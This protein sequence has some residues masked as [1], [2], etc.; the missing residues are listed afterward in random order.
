MKHIGINEE[1]V[2]TEVL[3]TFLAVTFFYS[4]DNGFA[5]I[6]DL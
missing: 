5:W 1:Y 3:L 4:S 6:N 2:E